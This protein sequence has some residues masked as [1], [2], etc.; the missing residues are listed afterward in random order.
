MDKTNGGKSETP[1]IQDLRREPWSIFRAKKVRESLLLMVRRIL[2]FRLYGQTTKHTQPL[3]SASYIPRY[4]I[5]LLFA[6]YTSYRNR[7]STETIST[8]TPRESWRFRKDYPPRISL[9][10]LLLHHIDCFILR[11]DV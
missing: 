7:I 10:N 8:M 2:R 6:A 11:A 1:E 4:H 9:A 3:P 5:V